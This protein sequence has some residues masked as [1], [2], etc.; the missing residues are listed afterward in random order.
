M[1]QLM[2]D[3]YI[4]RRKNS[5][6]TYVVLTWQI[7]QTSIASAMEYRASFLIKVG[8]MIIN[9]FGHLVLWLVFFAKF[10][11]VNGWNIHDTVLLL[12]LSMLMYGLLVLVSGGVIEISRTIAN[13]G[14]DY[15]LGLPKNPLW[16]ISVDRTE[17]AGLGDL[18]FG[19]GLFLIAGNPTITR[20]LILL[21]VA[22]LASFIMYNFTV[23]VQSL[24]FYF[25]DFEE[26]AERWFW[27]MLGFGFYPQ[28]IFFGALKV[29]MLTILPVFFIY[30][31]PIRII[32]HF[33]WLDLAILL[34]A[35]IA[36]F[37][38]AQLV[39]RSG[40]KRYESGNLINSRI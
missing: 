27:T 30:S 3:N 31:V 11:S 38:L 26:S 10:P 13:G 16:H 39:F 12:S 20:I 34:A 8:G 4:K 25:G 22:L 7:M 29:A 33:G 35:A 28:N 2:A 40:L 6:W 37:V 21:A 15:Y 36:S 5:F 17:I 32:Q 23:I 1:S 14:F 19:L 9:D 18:I 24:A